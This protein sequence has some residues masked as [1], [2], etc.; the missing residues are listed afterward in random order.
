MP[1]PNRQQ[2]DR[3]PEKLPEKPQTGMA[4]GLRVSLEI[5]LV[6]VGIALCAGIAKGLAPAL[7]GLAGLLRLFLNPVFLVLAVAGFLLFRVG[8]GRKRDR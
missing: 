5:L 1:S 8:R 7:P 2:P 3:T 4:K 6:L